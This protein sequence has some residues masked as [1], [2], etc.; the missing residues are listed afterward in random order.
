M[1]KKKTIRIEFY[2]VELGRTIGYDEQKL[3]RIPENFDYETFVEIGDNRYTVVGAEP[4][5][6]KELKKAEVLVLQIKKVER[7]EHLEEKKQAREENP[8]AE[9][10]SEKNAIHPSQVISEA[11]I[12]P[13]RTYF[14]PSKPDEFPAF[15]GSKE[16]KH[17]L[18][19]GAWEWR[20]AEFAHEVF[21]EAIRNEFFKIEKARDKYALEDPV[22]TV[23]TQQHRR[24]FAER[25]LGKL[26]L[27]AE[28][29][30]SQFFPDANPLDG[31]TFMKS[32]GFADGGFAF[33][34]P[35]G[36]PLYGMEI[37]ERVRHLALLPNGPRQ[38]HLV[39]ADIQTML[40]FMQA[41]SLLLVDWNHRQILR[42]TRED[43]AAW[44]DLE[45]DEEEEAD[46]IPWT[47]SGE[48]PEETNAG[49]PGPGELVAVV[50]DGTED[51]GMALVTEETE[52][53]E[54]DAE[55]AVVAEAVE[56]E[57]EAEVNA[58]EEETLEDVVAAL[59]TEAAEET[60]A[61]AED[62]TEGESEADE[63]IAEE[64]EPLPELKV[65]ELDDLTGEEE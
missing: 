20:Q 25:P 11:S 21:A 19:M 52:E 26:D 42:A 5:E 58:A 7:P 50:K 18:E 41:N 39:E 55:P 65:I 61:V 37:G 28:A 30:R 33:R 3:K 14:S 49:E 32:D 12:Q 8:H 4:K 34:L 35:S 48:E 46:H 29:L 59:E 53:A 38:V 9:I 31:V 64:A 56:G 27:D 6:R 10:F 63:A 43:L 15:T 2:D 36:I 62:T 13:R 45:A 60:E 51:H 22:R 17:L 16:G 57:D 40:E 24:L 44:L 47:G 1:F 54:T 23:F